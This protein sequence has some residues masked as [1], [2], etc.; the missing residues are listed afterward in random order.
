MYETAA[1]RKRRQEE[2]RKRRSYGLREYE[3]AEF[4]QALGDIAA[5]TINSLSDDS[6][7]SPSPSD[8]SSSSCDTSSSSS[9]SCGCD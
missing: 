6:Q 2:N 7:C 4:A 5:S 9:G 1:Q 3:A 8:S